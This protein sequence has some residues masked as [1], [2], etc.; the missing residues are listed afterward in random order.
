MRARHLIL[1][2]ASVALA[3]CT[4]GD[5]SVEERPV[6]TG[7]SVEA[8]APGEPF[9]GTDLPEVTLVAPPLE[10]AGEVPTFEWE[11][12]EGAATYR[13]AVLNGD[14]EA[15]WSWEGEST[16]VA[17]GGLSV[18]RPEGEPGP[19]ITAGSSWSVAA[20]DADGHVLALSVLRPVSP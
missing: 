1:A 14:G 7:S 19:V 12:V 5:R 11:P 10:G 3:A 13:L 4:G 20:L 2:L 8:G 15:V 18:D 6:A 9:E 16:E 17:L